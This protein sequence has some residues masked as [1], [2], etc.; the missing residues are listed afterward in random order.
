MFRV[1]AT[2]IALAFLVATAVHAE[3][4]PEEEEDFS[5]Q[6]LYLGVYG[7]YALNAYRNTGKDYGNSPGAN[8]RLGYRGNEW[9]A[10]EAV[11]E[12]IHRFENHGPDV[13]T[14]TLIGGVNVKGYP[15]QGR[16]QPYGLIG[17]NGYGI[18]SA[19]KKSNEDFHDADWGFRFGIG[20]DI[21]ANRNWVVGLESS[22][23]LGAGE[24]WDADY[25]SFGVG[26]QYR[27]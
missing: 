25:A 6:G 8:F 1:F 16:F 2:S 9:F 11:L 22:Y 24:L 26:L 14:R 21:Y 7:V 19:H 5:R 3:A 13:Q 20:L 4:P 15:L 18:K 17:V 27:F 10:M 12:W 23:V